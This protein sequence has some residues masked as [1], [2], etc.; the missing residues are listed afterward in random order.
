MAIETQF[1]K[2][3]HAQPSVKWSFSAIFFIAFG[4]HAEQA[5]GDASL[6]PVTISGHTGEAAAD[7]TGF[8][9]TPLRDLPLSATVVNRAQLDAIGARRLSDVAP[10][11]AS[12]TDG[13][14]SPGY[15][16]FVSIRGF[17]LDNRFNYR[18]EG[19]PISAE[20][21][22]PL[23]NKER[24]EILRGTSGIQA[25]TSGPGG[26]VNYVVKRPTERNL[27]ELRVDASERASLLAAVDLGGRF[28]AD[29][30][31]GYRVNLARENLRPLIRHLDG[32]RSLAS[33][34]ADWRLGGDALLEAEIEW[35]RRSQPSQSGFSLLG[36]TLPAPPDPRL[37]LNNQPWA[38]A[39]DFEALTGS[40]RFEQAIDSRWRWSLQA[41]RQLLKSNDRMAFA[42]G[43]G[44]EG[45]FDR[46]CSDGTFDVYDFR[47][48]NERRVQQAASLNLKGSAVTGQVRHQISLGLQTSQ[49]RQRFEAQAYNWVGTG[50][51]D[52]SATVPADPTRTYPSTNRDERSLEFFAQDAMAWT[53]RFTTWA[54]IR[55]TRLQRDSIGTDGT[56]QT[57]YSQGLATPWLAASYR[58][59]PTRLLYASYGEAVESH[60]VP[61]LPAQYTNAGAA[62]PALKSRQKEIGLRDGDAAR[63]WQLTWFE[64]NRPLW[65]DHCTDALCTRQIDGQTRHRGL[66][67]TAGLMA[68]A[69]N[70]DV[71]A[72]W[73]S[74]RRHGS[75]VNPLLEGKAETNVPRTVLRASASYRVQ[76]VPGL[77]LR[78]S[79]SRE[80]RRA[81]LPD[82]TLFLPAW[83]RAD[84]GL[85]YRTKLG[86]SLVRWTVAVDN[87]FDK[88][89][90][91]E[92]PN[93]FSHVYLFPGSP[94]TWRLSMQATF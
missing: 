4:V 17:V 60:V 19:L 90:W 70:V 1:L 81:V 24:I 94:R 33:L 89:Y 6:A 38:Q 80:G 8:G 92:S 57:T 22:I 36:L 45:A 32:Q 34:A 42:F 71:G 64:I 41:G 66:E 65:G 46:F 55:Q 72:T 43:C 9:D 29:G 11:D 25:G 62:L 7:I 23:D 56:G 35:S 39:S 14:N 47:S 54:G 13:Y 84:A 3:K 2:K 86:R 82:G 79:L 50:R 48:D 31:F 69:W 51:I 87:V 49:V 88:R 44:A 28:G 61:N 59:T 20:T 73:L 67:M 37:N 21:T 78:G 12:I 27:R 75:L 91:K 83:T 15:W 16:D 10:F 93:Q 74:A 76:G 85:T 52:G 53:D 58:L 30:R 68:G 5:G 77:E 40:V 26:L 18:R 63:H